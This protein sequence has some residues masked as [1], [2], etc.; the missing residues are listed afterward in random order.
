MNKMASN[1]LILE[2]GLPGLNE[3]IKAAKTPT[4]GKRA[5]HGVVYAAMKKK[6][7]QMVEA[8]GGR[9]RDPD[10]IRVGAK[11]V[12]DAM[13]NQGVIKDDS[14]KYVKILRDSFMKGTGRAVI[15]RWIAH[16]EE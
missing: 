1:E 4:R 16:T 11:F 13:V 15:V 10:N 3:I 8:E 2:F 9:A 7:T 5:Y 12:L 6:Y 14:M